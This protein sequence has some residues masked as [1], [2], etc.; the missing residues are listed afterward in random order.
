MVVIVHP[1][2][3]V[4]YPPFLLGFQISSHYVS[5]HFLLIQIVRVGCYKFIFLH[6]YLL[7]AHSDAKL[8]KNSISGGQIGNSNLTTFT[9][10]E[11]RTATQNFRPTKGL[12]SVSKG[13]VDEA[14]HRQSNIGIG[15]AIAVKFFPE[16][17][18]QATELQ[19]QVNHFTY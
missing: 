4:T 5:V 11:L 8:S 14:T 18:L 9:F 7:S 2:V 1:F 3:V 13:W 16:L 10:S 12:G 17:F 6:F 19:L 15:V